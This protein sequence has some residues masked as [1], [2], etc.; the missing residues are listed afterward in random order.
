MDPLTALSLAGTVVQFVDFGCKLLSEGRQLY[1]STSGKL[2]SNEEIE[3]ITLDLQIL[4]KKLQVSP[5]PSVPGALTKQQAEETRSLQLICDQ[6]SSIAEEMI[7][8]LEKVALPSNAPRKTAKTFKQLLKA[9]LSSHKIADMVARLTELRKAI[10]TNLLFSAK[11][12]IDLQAVRL[13][14]RFD[15]MDVQTQRILTS[16]LENQNAVNQQVIT[17]V[18]Q[19]MSRLEVANDKAHQQTQSILSERYNMEHMVDITTNISML[20]VSSEEETNL[21]KDIQAT[22]IESLQYPTMTSRYEDIGEAFPQTLE[23]AFQDQTDENLPRANLATWLK[24]GKG[25]YWVSGKPGSGK[26]TL[27]KHLFDDRR[28]WQYLQD[29][30]KTIDPIDAPLHIATFFFWNS[31]T[32]EQK[33]QAGLL[34]ALIYQILKQTPDLVPIVFPAFWADVYSKYLDRQE[35]ESK[36]LVASKRWQLRE[37][38]MAMKLLVGQTQVPIKLFFLIDGLDEF[39]EDHEDLVII[40]RDITHLSKGRSKICLSSR[41]WVIFEDSFRACAGLKMQNL[42]YK[43]IEIYVNERLYENPAFQRLAEEEPEEMSELIRELVQKADGV[44]LWVR[45][46]VKSLLSGIRNLDEM[47]DLWRRL[48]LLPKELEPLYEHLMGRIEPIYMEWASK[49]FRIVQTSR[50]IDEKTGTQRKIQL[51]DRLT[52]IV[53][54]LAINDNCSLEDIR[55]MKPESIDSKCRTCAVQLTARCAGFLEISTS[56]DQETAAPTSCVVFLHRTAR[57][58]LEDKTR[59]KKLLAVTLGTSF[60]PAYA[61]VKGLSLSVVLEWSL[62]GEGH[63]YRVTKEMCTIAIDAL[64]FAYQLSA[65]DS[66]W[67]QLLEIFEE[68][69][70]AVSWNEVGRQEWTYVLLPR[71]T[72]QTPILTFLDLAALFGVSQYVLRQ[73]PGLAIYKLSALLRLLLSFE[74]YPIVPARSEDIVSALLSYGA[75]LEEDMQNHELVRKLKK[76]GLTK[77]RKDVHCEDLFQQSGTVDESDSDSEDE[78]DGDKGVTKGQFQDIDKQPRIKRRKPDKEGYTLSASRQLRRMSMQ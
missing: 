9:R 78:S 73:L 69:G 39:E 11:E 66:A 5:L 1:K 72:P 23:W 13:A 64:R 25:Q 29:W 28:T 42:T 4:V 47:S 54:Y 56:E 15:Q 67:D 77:K 45:I 26:S 36:A 3:I 38:K 8:E 31:G 74:P 76:Q 49:V 71:S 63:S 2:Q 43:D 6:A 52:L 19:M 27:M 61:L 37:L 75:V 18:A 68:M 60:G 55:K 59:W 62:Y 22:I 57:D 21:R 7:R 58:F 24:T 16:L 44:F 30:A 12:N 20:A 10:D 48:R 41:P 50:G 17:A 32:P 51:H 33:S 65:Q 53:L 35:R 46:V 70:K 40:F 14:A 34:R